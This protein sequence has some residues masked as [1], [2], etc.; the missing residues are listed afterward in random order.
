MLLPAG[1]DVTPPVAKQ[2]PHTIS[3][4]AETLTDPYFWLR[5][6]NNPEVIQYL[7]A[8]N[9]YTEAVMKHTDGLQTR[10][11]QEILGRIK[12][13]DLSVPE[14]IDDYYYYSRT[15]Q[16]KQYGIYCRKKGSLDA[17]EE[18]LLDQNELAQGHKYFRVGNLK[19]SP[20]HKLLAYS[21]DA[22]GSEKYTLYAKDLASGKLL[23]DQVPNTYYGL[24]WG[25]DN[26]TLFYTTLD[27]TQ[28]PYKLYRHKLG[29]DPKQDALLFHEKDDMFFL[30]IG[31]TRSHRYLMLSLES[32]TTSEV[33]YLDASRPSGDFK[34]IHPRQKDMEYSVEHHGDKFFIVT[35]ENAKNFKLMEVTTENPKKTNWKEVIPHR[36]SV[37]L[38]DVDAFRDHL[39][40]SER[41]DGLKKIRVR[42][43]KTGETH[44][45]EFP[46]PV[47][48]FH[49]SANPEYN[50]TLLRFNYTSLVT[51]RS[52]F[53]YDMNTRKRDLKK[54]FEVLGGYDATQYRSERIFATASDGTRIPISMVYRKGME[55][56]ARNPLLLYGYGS[57]GLSTDPMFSSDRLSLLDRGFIYAIAHIRGGGEMGRPWYDDGKLLHK[58][59]TFTD[60]IAC[61]EHLITQKYTAS[62]RLVIYGGSAGGLLMGAVTNMRRDL[63]KIVIAK[64]PF[65]DVINTM[66]DESIPLTVTEFEEC[67]PKNKE[68][69]QYMKA[70]SPYDNVQ[71]KGYPHMLITT[72][73]NDPRVAFW[74]PAKWTAKLRKTKTDRNVLLLKTNMGAGHG[75]ASGRY[76]R[77]KETAFEYAFILDLLGIPQ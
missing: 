65:V 62:D 5:D 17:A 51:P 20:D 74:E 60:F 35:N 24:E 72:G 11:Y 56:N 41:E 48:T 6:R 7:E 2:V 69:Y 10:L 39:V 57:Y 59:N 63:F 45:V 19:P 73:L 61:A 38:D 54:Q 33:H 12:E 16:G 1:V 23:A 22:N 43:M 28:R 49:L 55:R 30:R 46:E 34:V 18:I 68:Y 26:A 15:E 52:V 40:I 14:K 3:L 21:T 27:E 8:E 29:S 58:K 71:A 67:N 53:D 75:G 76:D 25:N 47:Y 32:K 9:R 36:A 42:N 66:L 13:T 77:I 64:V 4:H 44:T 31:K 50:T 70:Y 37:K